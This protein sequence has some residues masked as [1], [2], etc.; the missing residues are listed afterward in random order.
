M[1]ATQL[2]Q[3]F[4]AGDPPQGLPLERPQFVVS[5]HP[6]QLGET[7]GKRVE[8]PVK[9][10]IALREVARQHQPVMR[11]GC[12][13]SHCVPIGGVVKVEVGERQQ[14]GAGHDGGPPMYSMSSTPSFP[15]MAT[16]PKERP[17]ASVPRS[18]VSASQALS[19]IHI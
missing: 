8:E 6:D 11:V 14:P 3:G 9:F 19:L 15:F 7:G 10:L 17:E 5:G 1:L 2:H 16:V 12:Q 18:R 4:V 13:S